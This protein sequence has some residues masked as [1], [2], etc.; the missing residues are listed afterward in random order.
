M[1]HSGFVPHSCDTFWESPPL[2]G[3]G[4]VVFGK[5]C[6][7][8]HRGGSHESRRHPRGHAAA[9]TWYHE[10]ELRKILANSTAASQGGGYPLGVP[11]NEP[12]RVPPTKDS[13]NF[14]GFAGFSFWFPAETT[15]TGAPTPSFLETGGLWQC[16][17]S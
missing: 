3:G 15:K 8:Y 4:G 2:Y 10:E 5:P 16:T 9:G 14:V 17:F 6:L 13:P 12:R 7:W 1:D 11:F